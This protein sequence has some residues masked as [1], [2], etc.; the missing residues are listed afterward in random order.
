MLVL[1]GISLGVGYLVV[2][3]ISKQVSGIFKRLISSLGADFDT[4]TVLEPYILILFSLLSF[5]ILMSTVGVLVHRFVVKP[6]IVIDK[7]KKRTIHSRLTCMILMGGGALPFNSLLATTVSSTIQIVGYDKLFDFNE[8]NNNVKLLS[9]TCFNM[10]PAEFDTLN[11]ATA[12]LLKAVYG[13][14]N[15]FTQM[16]KFMDVN[17]DTPENIVT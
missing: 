1:Y 7:K 2:P 5:V 12:N 16:E 13:N 3:L 8:I 15:Y 9:L 6:R 10:S 17:P 11:F 14:T 4:S